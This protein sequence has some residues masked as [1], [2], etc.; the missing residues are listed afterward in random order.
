MSGAEVGLRTPS[1]GAIVARLR[2]SAGF[3]RLPLYAA[4]AL[5]AL[6]SNY[7]LGREVLWDTLDY[8][9]YAGFSAVHDRF[10][11]DYFAGGPGSYFDP[12]AYVP[13]YLLVNAGIPALAIASLLAVVQGGILWVTYELALCACPSNGRRVCIAVGLWSIVLAF[14]NPVLIEQLGSSYADITTGALA[15]L[16][17]LLLA[18][19]VRAPRAWLPLCAGLVLGAATALK[20]TNAV[21]SVA[22]FALIIMMPRPAEA[23]RSGIYYTGALALSFAAAAGPWAYQ[24]A[25]H[26]G[27]PFFP[28]LNTIF[29]SPEFTT[30]PLRHFRFIPA[31]LLEGLW[32]PFALADPVPMV[33]VEDSAPDLRY[34]ALL[35]LVALIVFRWLW[36]RWRARP[37]APVPTQSRP[38]TRV[39][40]GLMLALAIDWVLWLTASGNGRYFLPAAC[41][42]A[43]VLVALVFRVWE[44]RP[45]LQAYLLSA[46][47]ASQALAV[48]VGS[49]YRWSPVPW[50][51][52]WFEVQVPPRLAS[53][54]NL[55]LTMGAQSN[56]FLAPYLARESGLINFTGVYPLSPRGATGAHIAALIDRYSPH[57]RVLLRGA[58]LYEKDERREPQQA[59]VDAALARFGLR[60][61]PADCATIAVHGVPPDPESLIT[62]GSLP[63]ERPPPGTIDLLSCHV[64]ADNTDHSA[65]IARERAV[66]QVFDHL[67]YAC[68]QLFQPRGMLTE[69]S[70]VSRW[71][72]LYVNTDL[73]AWVSHGEVKFV[74]ALHGDDP[75]DLGHESDWESAPLRLVCGRRYGHYFARVLNSRPRP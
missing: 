13:F 57:V 40:A 16:G 62:L 10:A 2:G 49:E 7:L 33:Q 3:Y 27:N 15:L 50:G 9:L 70:S 20:L 41:V 53:E 21:H 38:G 69:H 17:W 28:L 48:F 52:P 73:R 46:V 12:Y 71:Q 59:T 45:R 60:V 5:L 22:A 6:L 63:L 24:L 32:R 56:A 55:Y 54:P 58:R 18:R 67:E 66:D 65:E 14:L 74:D 61:D 75:V 8:H 11:Q 51:G 29:R 43:V 72:R 30:E 36:Q 68:P 44:V 64:V 42:T 19:A 47:V 25:R 26:F 31:S 1:G 4:C 39:L 37:G 23:V 34:A 35:A